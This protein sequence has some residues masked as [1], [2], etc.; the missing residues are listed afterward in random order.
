MN[1]GETQDEHRKKTGKPGMSQNQTRNEPER[2]PGNLYN[3][4]PNEQAYYQRVDSAG[5]LF[6][7]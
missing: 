3:A 5:K 4:Q 6:R 2:K 7:E 1:L